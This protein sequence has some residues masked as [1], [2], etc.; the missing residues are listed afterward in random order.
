MAGR[1]KPE[2]L[3]EFLLGELRRAF[4]DIRQRVVEE[5]WFGRVTTPY[6]RNAVDH[7]PAREGAVEPQRE[8]SFDDLYGHRREGQVAAPEHDPEH[9]RGID[10]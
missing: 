2:G 1:G 5:G 9:D 8:L 4:Q 10:R 7:G 6:Q 3:G